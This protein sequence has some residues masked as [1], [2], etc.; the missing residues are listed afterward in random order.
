MNKRM[1]FIMLFTLMLPIA[2]QARIGEILVEGLAVN[3][4]CEKAVSCYNLSV[5][6]TGRVTFVIQSDSVVGRTRLTAVH[7]AE[8]KAVS[9]VKTTISENFSEASLLEIFAEDICIGA[10]AIGCGEWMVGKNSLYRIG[11]DVDA[12]RVL[13]SVDDFTEI[14][15]NFVP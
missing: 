13:T 7:G 6:K 15:I 3:Q 10:A 8:Q 11:F 5:S 14:R 4:N 2:A 12:N 9:T 1:K